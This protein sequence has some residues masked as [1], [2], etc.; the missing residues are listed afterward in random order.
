[1]PERCPLEEEAVE[2]AEAGVEA[3]VDEVRVGMP[4]VS[5]L[6]AGGKEIMRLGRVN[7]VLPTVAISSSPALACNSRHSQRVKWTPSS[8]KVL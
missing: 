8:L 2:K 4:V 7:P 6:P 1:M 5:S 3:E